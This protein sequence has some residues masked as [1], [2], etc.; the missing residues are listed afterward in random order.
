MVLTV[1]AH[2]AAIHSPERKRAWPRS[3]RPCSL[4]PCSDCLAVFRT[5]SLIILESWIFESLRGHP[6]QRSTLEQCVDEGRNGRTLSEDNE[7]SDQEQAHHHRHQPPPFIA[8][9]EGEQLAGNTHVPNAV[10]NEFHDFPSTRE[11]AHRAP[12]KI[13][14]LGLASSSY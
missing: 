9:E 11:R 10:S 4:R 13:V 8:H 14:R 12:F 5:V 6:A 1:S 3:F 7:G 2:S